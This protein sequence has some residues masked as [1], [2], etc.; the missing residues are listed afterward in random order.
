M[1]ASLTIAIYLVVWWIALFAVLPFRF[2]E[3]E[4]PGADPFADAAGAPSNPR[5]KLK[6]ILATVVS[7]VIVGALYAAVALGL[8]ALGPP[9]L[10]PGAQ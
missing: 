7:G 10:A 4:A 8:F 2:G 1:S 6:F 3:P 9:S 5:L